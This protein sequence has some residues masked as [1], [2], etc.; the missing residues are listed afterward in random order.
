MKLNDLGDGDNDQDEEEEQRQIEFLNE[1]ENLER[2]S[3]LEGDGDDDDDDD[4]DDAS[5][6]SFL[7]NAIDKDLL[8]GNMHHTDDEDGDGF[9]SNKQTGNTL[10]DR[11]LEMER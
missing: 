11:E 6:R 8:E 3:S 7:V 2:R 9:G 4:D 5:D 1:L 10:H